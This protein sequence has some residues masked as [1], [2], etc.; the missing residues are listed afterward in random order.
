MT[1]TYVPLP[2]AGMSAQT[3]SFAGMG[4]HLVGVRIYLCV[5]QVSFKVEKA[6]L[7]NV[8]VFI[9]SL[10]TVQEGRDQFVQSK[11]IRPATDIWTSIFYFQIIYYS[12]SQLTLA[13]LF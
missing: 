1:L 6:G 8:H 4:M 7:V 9:S 3:V 2:W 11:L 10:S 13:R 5:F 12:V